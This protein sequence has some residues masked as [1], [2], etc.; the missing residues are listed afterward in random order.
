MRF[1]PE[2]FNILISAVLHMTFTSSGA[3]ANGVKEGSVM[4]GLSKEA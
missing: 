4:S 3:I 2:S 1:P